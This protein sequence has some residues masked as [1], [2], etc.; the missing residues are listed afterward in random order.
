MTTEK[1]WYVV[2]TKP[3]WEKKVSDLLTKKKIDNYCPLNKVV[4]QWADRKKMILEPL[5]TSYVF[6]HATEAE[7]LAVK[8]TSGI[9]NF[10]YWLGS[11]AVVKD[12]EID[13]IKSFLEKYTNI[14]L[15]KVEINVADRV[16]ITEGLFVDRE[17]EVTEV[18]NKTVKI[19]LPSLSYVMMAEVSKTSVEVINFTQ[20]SYPPGAYINAKAG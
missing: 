12:N 2:Y 15:E 5:F 1:K 8:Q 11:P 16:R 18:R 10:V 19:F 4:R 17:G 13:T 6:V 20:P 9:V 3:R 14:T 7:H